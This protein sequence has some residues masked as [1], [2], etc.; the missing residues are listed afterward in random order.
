VETQ[1]PEAEEDMGEAAED[2][3]MG[4]VGVEDE[5]EDDMDKAEGDAGVEGDDINMGETEG[6][7]AGMQAGGDADVEA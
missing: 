3:D 2:A 1:N 7:P 6:E 5:A 4:Q